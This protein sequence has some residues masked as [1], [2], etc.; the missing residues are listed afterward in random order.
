MKSA[1][2]AWDWKENPP[3]AAIISAANKIPK[4]KLW[5]FAERGD[6]NVVC[7]AATKADAVK[8]YITEHK[9]WIRGEWQGWKD[10]NKFNTKTFEQFSR[11]FALEQ[12]TRW[13]G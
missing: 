10:E 11:E 2:F 9:D 4:A 5:D 7:I 3:L 6:T 1:I 12:I 8:A 13:E